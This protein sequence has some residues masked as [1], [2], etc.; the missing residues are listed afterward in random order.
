M[1]KPSQKRKKQSVVMT[2]TAVEPKEMAWPTAQI[3]IM[4]SVKP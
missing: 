3:T 1:P 4:T 2:A